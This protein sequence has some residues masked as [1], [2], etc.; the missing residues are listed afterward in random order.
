MPVSPMVLHGSLRPACPACCEERCP[1]P[2]QCLTWLTSNAWGK[3]TECD[4]TRWAGDNSF[5]LLCGWCHG[6][7]LEE[8]RPDAFDPALDTTPDLIARHASLVAA[9]RARVPQVVAA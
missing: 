5:Q 9:L 4:G 6:T 7:G 8:Y 3:C 1:D 2:A